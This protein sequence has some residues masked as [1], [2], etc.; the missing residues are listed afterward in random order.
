MPSFRWKASMGSAAPRDVTGWL[1]AWSEGD[2][3]ALA[4][5]VPVVHEELRRLAHRYMRRE[6]RGHLLQTTALVNEAYL[7]L[8]D[9][10]QL[11]WRNRAHFLA[12]AARVMREILVDFA[13]QRKARKRGGDRTL[14]RFDEAL[15]VAG[16]RTL[17]LEALNEALTT[18]ASIDHRKSRVVEL[19][20]FGG[21]TTPE[22]AEVLDVSPNT[23]LAD[24][25]F[26][27]AWLSREMARER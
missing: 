17:D 18:L 24:W 26:A 8:V 2:E 21:L 4:R 20:F 10:K 16:E 7:R 22:I 25:S 15:G 1:Q 13:R 3:S 12:I 9:A 23:V 14:V 11:H 19:R 27:K 6:Q 5:I